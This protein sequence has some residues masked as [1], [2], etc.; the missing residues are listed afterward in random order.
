MDENV[1]TAVGGDYN[2][3][4]NIESLDSA[5]EKLKNLLN[6]IEDTLKQAD[7]A[8]KR[9]VEAAGGDSTRVGQAIQQ[10]LVAVT[11]N[12]FNRVKER[13]ANLTNGVQIIEKAYVEEEDELVKAVN[14]Y[15]DGYQG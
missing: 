3:E 9:A 2:V 1:V 6:Q 14:N 7:E 11:S 15:R 5:H 10:S 8:G 4:V 12:E 13:V